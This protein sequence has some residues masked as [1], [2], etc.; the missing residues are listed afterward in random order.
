MQ[1]IITGRSVVTSDEFLFLTLDLVEPGEINRNVSE[2]L[3]YK[4]LIHSLNAFPSTS[5]WLFFPKDIKCEKASLISNLGEMKG[6]CVRT[7]EN[8]R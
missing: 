6:N 3:K 8:G 5:F 2:I 4:K 1:E 7:S